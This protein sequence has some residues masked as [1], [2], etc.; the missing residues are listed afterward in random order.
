[1]TRIT[2]LT[3]LQQ[4]LQTEITLH[5]QLLLHLQEE[6]S[7]F[8][9]LNGS[10]L[11]RVQ[12]SKE[13]CVEQIIKQEEIRVA[14]I[15]QF[16]QHWPEQPPPFTLR[17][18]IPLA[19]PE[20]GGALRQSF[21]QLQ[22]LLANIR[23]LAENNGKESSVRLRSVEASMRFLTDS[24]QRQQPTYSGSGELQHSGNKVPRISV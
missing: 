14:L 19:P 21:D 1:M 11:L 13:R 18:I 7:G 23:E 9:V 6:A 10:E 15:A 4:I 3:E 17:V 12:R 5:E 16:P 24:Q 22:L 20:L 8:G 2:L